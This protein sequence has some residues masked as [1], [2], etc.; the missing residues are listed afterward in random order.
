M[1]SRSCVINCGDNVAKTRLVPS[2]NIYVMAKERQKARIFRLG[3][4]LWIAE[5]GNVSVAAAR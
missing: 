4:K 1:M 2:L 3:R 5:I